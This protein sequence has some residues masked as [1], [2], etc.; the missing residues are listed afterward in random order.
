MSFRLTNSH[1]SWIRCKPSLIQSHFFLA[2]SPFRL[3]SVIWLLCSGLDFMVRPL[4]IFAGE[5][6]AGAREE[7]WGT[8]RDCKP[9][10]T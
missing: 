6:Q 5:F 1:R 4:F 10:R 8:E 9:V 7:D 3:G 2:R